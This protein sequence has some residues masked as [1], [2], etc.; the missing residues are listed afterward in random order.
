[1]FAT[2]RSFMRALGWSGVGAA[3]LRPAELFAARGRESL[4]GLWQ[5]AGAPAIPVS[6]NALRLK[7]NENPLGPG[8]N[9]LAAIRP[10]LS[11]ANRYPYDMERELQA[12]IARAHGVPE[13][14][15]TVGCGSGEI[16][17]TPVP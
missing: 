1:M 7:S 15:V 3:T 5:T 12:A 14:H 10:A 13:D 9:V 8:E 2:R 6:K 4:G 16:F 17:W 11:E